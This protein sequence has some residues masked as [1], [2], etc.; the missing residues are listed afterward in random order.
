M[1]HTFGPAHAHRLPRLQVKG[2]MGHILHAP[3]HHIIA[4]PDDIFGKP[5]KTAKTGNGPEKD[6]F[7]GRQ[8][9]C[10]ITQGCQANMRRLGHDDDIGIRQN[11]LCITTDIIEPCR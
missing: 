7:I 1:Q 9:L 10:D 4:R 6:L 8:G 2:G 3:N 11:I 5:V